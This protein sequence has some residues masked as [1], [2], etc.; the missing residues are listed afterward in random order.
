MFSSNIVNKSEVENGKI[1][2]KWVANRFRWLQWIQMEATE[3]ICTIN[4]S[5]LWIGEEKPGAVHPS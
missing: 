1:L 2:F 3:E 4:S 5:K